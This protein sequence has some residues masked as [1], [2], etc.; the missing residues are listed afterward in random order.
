MCI[1]ILIY[2][3]TRIVNTRDLCI[4]IYMCICIHMC[5]YTY[6]YMCLYI[7][8]YIY[9]YIYTCIYVYTYM[10]TSICIHIAYIYGWV[11]AAVGCQKLLRR[12]AVADLALVSLGRRKHL[13]RSVIQ[14][15]GPKFLCGC[16]KLWSLFRSLV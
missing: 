15:F 4:Y 7:Y 12:S 5:I 3:H 1:C 2:I 8:I 10:Y 6:M 13:Q 9:M 14:S 11:A 16:Q